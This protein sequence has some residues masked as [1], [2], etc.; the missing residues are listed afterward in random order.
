M[1]LATIY[2]EALG[3]PAMPGILL[4]NEKDAPAM[5]V[6]TFLRALGV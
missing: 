3:R 2:T 4:E 5:Y 1:L 6:R